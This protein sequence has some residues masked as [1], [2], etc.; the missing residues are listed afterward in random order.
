MAGFNCSYLPIDHPKAFDEMMYVL[1]CG[2]GVG[3][4]VERQYISKLPEVAE[5]FHDTDTVIHVAD[6]KIGWAKAYR[7][8]VAMLY[9]GQVPKRDVSGVRPAG[10]PLK[11]FGGRASGPEPLVDLFQFTIEVFRNAAGRRLNS[12]ECHDLCCKIAQVVVVGGVAGGASVAARARRLDESAEIVVL[13][14]GEYVS[15]ANCGLPYHIGG[16]IADRSRLLLQTPESLR[17]S[18]DIDVRIGQDVVGLDRAAQT[19]TVREVATGREYTESYDALALCQGADPLQLPL[20]GIDLPGIHTLRNVADM[21]AIKSRLD[22]VLA[23]AAS[24]GR[25]AKTVVIGAGYIGIEMAEN[26]I[27]RGA[28]VTIVE[29][30]DQILPPLDKDVSIPVEQ[31]ARGR[32]VELQLGTA[33][34]AFTQASDGMLR[35]ELNNGQSLPADLVV[36]SAGVRPNVTLAREAGLE[37]GERG[38]IV[39]DTHMRTSDPHIWAAG[40]AVETA[41]TVLRP[42]E[43]ARCDRLRS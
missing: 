6:S 35:V 29:L 38:G 37:I 10:S 36:L 16:V 12:I 18:L 28:E 41:H 21:D 20:P 43:P 24:R 23:A 19:V 26:L 15:F 13:E 34:A 9:I 40:D 30:A 22:E 5:K 25:A 3:F 31:H 33:A 39:V 17:E 4:S 14:R 27:H 7:E 11:T 32:G 8:L 42:G 2:T 1:M